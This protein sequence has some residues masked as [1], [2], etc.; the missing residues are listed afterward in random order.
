MSALSFLNRSPDRRRLL[1]I[2]AGVLLAALSSLATGLRA[3]PGEHESRQSTAAPTPLLRVA[4]L[5]DPTTDLAYAD[6]LNRADEFSAIEDPPHNFGITGSAVWL[7]LEIDHRSRD[8]DSSTGESPAD[9]DGWLE[10]AWPY[11]DT[12]DYYE[13]DDAAPGGFEDRTIPETR[14][15]KYATGRSRPYDTRPLD[16]R[17]FVFPIQ[18]QPG[19]SRTIFLRIK[20]DTFLMAPLR[21]VS[22]DAFAFDREIEGYTLGAYY[23]M[24]LVVFFYSLFIY[25]SLR[26]SAFLS[27]CGYVLCLAIYQLCVNGIAYRF[28]PD[29]T[30]WNKYSLPV[31]LTLLMLAAMDFIRRFLSLRKTDPL[32]NRIWLLFGCLAL[33]LLAAVYVYYPTVK[34][35]IN[36]ATFF[37]VL[38][39]ITGVRS[40]RLGNHSA[41]WFMV[42]WLAP[43]V[44]FLVQ[45]SGTYGLVPG[46]SGMIYAGQFGTALE[47]VLL[48]LAMAD[49]INDLKKEQ[50]SWNLR[51]ENQ[52]RQRTV[53]LNTALNEIHRES[54]LHRIELDIAAGIQK[55]IMPASETQT[56]RA[57]AVTYLQSLAPVGGDYFDV[58]EF[59]D[60]GHTAFLMADAS[61]H[62]I[63]AAL[64]TTMAKIC[65]MDATRNQ[66]P[67]PREILLAVNDAIARLIK[68]HEYLT[69]AMLI[70]GP[71][72]EAKYASA[73]HRR[74]FHYRRAGHAVDS[75]DTEGILLGIYENDVIPAH[76]TQH[77]APVSPGDRFLMF[78]DGFT[79]VKNGSDERFGE[80]RLIQL[81]AETAAQDL[82]QARDNILD[83]WREFQRHGSRDDDCTFTLIEF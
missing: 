4:A 51:L 21:L 5:I 58:F 64:I 67:N 81:L 27:Y 8:A 49:R 7:R 71:E 53:E 74:S 63:P 40:W 66:G 70:V 55:G 76:I 17:F 54:E 36:A 75:W 11:I 60:T 73:G 35:L 82:D 18:L 22:R 38:A 14:Q 25:S 33:A 10:L 3:E 56:Q 68:T 61:G 42:A 79:D 62:G 26:E 78:T 83:V 15:A 13:F 57:R 12:I 39:F 80:D 69:A 16:H 50:Q 24:L 2:Y 46:W 47:L 32:L 44:G 31:F 6:V 19:E 48:S 34:Y 37:L 45:L 59:K 23:G 1:L 29:A 77:E 65:F 30:L 28:W 41:R 72:G 20:S 43:I 9:F 52:V